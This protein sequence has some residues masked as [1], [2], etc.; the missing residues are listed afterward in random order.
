MA[1]ITPGDFDR[2][3]AQ[4]HARAGIVLGAHKKDM[5][6]RTLAQRAHAAGIPTVRQYLDQL[7]RNP[8]WPEWE[9]FV[10]AFTINHTA[11]FRERHHFDILADFVRTRHK[12]ISVWCSA[13]STGEEAYSIAMTLRETL[14]HPGTGVSVWATDIDTA[15]IQKAREGIYPIER[16]KPV[17]QECLQKYFQRGKGPRAGQV[18]VK[19]T[20]RSMIEFGVFNLLQEDW[21]PPASFDAIF[22][23][24][25]MIY[26]DKP[27]QTRILGRFAPTLK[28]GGLLFA[29]H[30]ENFTYLT[31]AFRL[32]GQTVY[33]KS[34]PC[35]GMTGGRES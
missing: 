20:L 29:G 22:C 24:N 23:R 18:R 35:A 15:A 25:T 17:P 14:G 13:A 6:C 30:S 10:N 8:R 16:V 32:Q 33:V 9:N 21:P 7:E 4:L 27:T 26:F 2:A 31:N 3:A 19:E 12:P 34:G 1:E 28:K 11:F 5:V